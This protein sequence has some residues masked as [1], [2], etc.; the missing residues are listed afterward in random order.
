MDTSEVYDLQSMYRLPGHIM[1]IMLSK[2]FLT[3]VF[4]FSYCR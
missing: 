3:T 4:Y 2:T 1:A